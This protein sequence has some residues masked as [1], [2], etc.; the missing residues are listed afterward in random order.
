MEF[1]MKKIIQFRDFFSGNFQGLIFEI[2]TEIFHSYIE[3]A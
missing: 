1:L 2:V 3:L